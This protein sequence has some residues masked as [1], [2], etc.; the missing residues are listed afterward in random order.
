[1]QTEREMVERAIN[2]TSLALKKVVFGFLIIVILIIV[3]I[4]YL[5]K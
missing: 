5:M 1:M 2:E 3:L 4:W